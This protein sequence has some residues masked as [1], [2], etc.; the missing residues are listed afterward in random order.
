MAFW[1]LLLAG[2]A[3]LSG[4]SDAASPPPPVAAPATGEARAADA[5]GTAG[6]PNG[7][8]AESVDAASLVLPAAADEGELLDALAYSDANGPNLLV[9]R[10]A[11]SISES[12]D[13]TVETI[14]LTVTH[15]LD[16][17]D[18]TAPGWQE[19]WRAGE[20]TH[21]D[22]LDFEAGF[23]ERATRVEDL[24]DDGIA[25]LVVG[26]SGFC[27][28]GID[29]HDIKLVLHAG[30]REYVLQGE[31]LVQPPD[32]SPS[33]GGHYATTPAS[34]DIP[35]PLRAALLEA[36]SRVKTHPIP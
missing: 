9:F 26:Y 1:P 33:F 22:G 8:Q 23:L 13:G 7:I 18:D 5:A 32:G 31:S 17:S 3:G 27:G 11:Q 15:Y 24:D 10:R 14:A 28:G 2:V 12:E 20:T 16:A 25:E 29:P 34:E 36:W 4:C 30:G 19:T 35:P 21:C 6:T